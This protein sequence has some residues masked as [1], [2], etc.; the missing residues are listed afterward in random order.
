MQCFV[1]QVQLTV[2]VHHRTVYRG[3]NEKPGME[4]LQ[5]A[6]ANALPEQMKM[7]LCRKWAAHNR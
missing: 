6:R 3:S 2:K 5:Q 7:P 1:V 4:Q